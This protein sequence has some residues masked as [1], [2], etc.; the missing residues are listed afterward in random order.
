MPPRNICTQNSAWVRRRSSARLG[1]GAGGGDP[2][3]TGSASLGRYRSLKLTRRSTERCFNKSATQSNA[4]KSLQ[5]YLKI[6]QVVN[7]QM[8]WSINKQGIIQLKC[9]RNILLISIQQLNWWRLIISI[10]SERLFVLLPSTFSTVLCQTTSV[11][12][13]S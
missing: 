5:T 12:K 1:P 9:R 2:I 4:P 8:N 6:K 11:N 10:F 13:D 7:I 3:G